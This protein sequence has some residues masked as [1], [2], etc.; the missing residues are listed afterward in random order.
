MY[1]VI[2][3]LVV[4][5][6]YL[7]FRHYKLPAENDSETY[8]RKKDYKRLSDRIFDTL[9]KMQCMPEKTGDNDIH[10]YFQGQHFIFVVPTDETI[11]TRLWYSGVGGISADSPNLLNMF[12]VINQCKQHSQA[13]IYI[14]EPEDDGKRYIHIFVDMV[15]HHEIANLPDY[16]RFALNECFRA[17]HALEHL[18]DVRA[19][20]SQSNRRPVG[21]G[22]PEQANQETAADTAT[23]STIENRSENRRRTVGFTIPQKEET[24]P[25]A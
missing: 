12:E 19:K 23:D 4:L 13:S 17:H 7:L 15:V 3:L 10:F 9:K 16:I 21:F 2:A 22:S 14:E 8:V 24:T 6:I 5:L 20:N 18:F 1:I 11:L 25:S